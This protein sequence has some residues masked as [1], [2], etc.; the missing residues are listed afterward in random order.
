MIPD[1]KI[2]KEEALSIAKIECDKIGKRW[3]PV[4]KEGL[5]NWCVYSPRDEKGG[6]TIYINQQNGKCR[7]CS[8]EL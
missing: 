7:S 1:P 4:I 3:D 8:M 2:Q 5:I 6:A